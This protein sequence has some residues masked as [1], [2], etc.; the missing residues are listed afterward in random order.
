MILPSA[1]ITGFRCVPRVLQISRSMCDQLESM[2]T[3]QDSLTVQYVL[4]L[5][6]PV[7]DDVGASSPCNML[8]SCAHCT[9][10]TGSESGAISACSNEPSTTVTVGEPHIISY[11]SGSFST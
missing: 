1:G 4:S 5:V 8:A 11:I 3:H 2:E 9:G 10:C 7:L 6:E